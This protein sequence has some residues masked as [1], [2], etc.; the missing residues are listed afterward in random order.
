MPTRKQ[1]ERMAATAAVGRTAP[2]TREPAPDDDLPAEYWQAVLDDA[3]ADARPNADPILTQRLCDIGRHLV[4]VGC[5]RCAR[6][7]EIQKADATR[8]YGPDTIWRDVGQRFLDNTCSQRTGRHEEDG[9][10]PKFE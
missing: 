8:L 1:M 7:V 2:P 6:I 3:S 10:W 5:R 9:C 4:R